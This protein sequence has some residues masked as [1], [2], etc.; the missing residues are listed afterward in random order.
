MLISLE[1]IKYH[2][3]LDGDPDSEIDVELERL[4]DVAVE[5]AS[6]YLGRPIPWTSPGTSPSSSETMVF[7]KSVEQ[8]VLILIA[9]YFENREQNVVGSIIQEN[10]TV[11]RLL[12]F[13]RVGLGI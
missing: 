7:P 3:R 6:Q 1:T 9:E 11:Q 4:H 2:L 13:H 8:A 5:Y 10:P 12:H